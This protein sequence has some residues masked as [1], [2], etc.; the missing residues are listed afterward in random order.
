MKAAWRVA[1]IVGGLVGAVVTGTVVGL[2][3][4]GLRRDGRSP[5]E[6]GERPEPVVTDPYRWPRP[7]REFTVAADDGLPLSVEETDPADGG[8]PDLTVVLVHGYTVDRRCWYFQRR[9]LA[10]LGRRPGEPRVRVVAY[11]QRSHGRSGRGPR[12]SCTLDQL[13]RDLDAVLRVVAPTGPVVLVGHSMG[14]MTIMALAEQHPELFLER[15]VGVALIGTSAGELGR[16]GLPRPVLSRYNPVTLG[17]GRLAGWQ[18]DLVER[19]RRVGNNLTWG[20]VRAL[21]F[22]SRQVDPH[23]VELV[24]RMIAETPVTVITHF[25]ETLGTHNRYAALAALRQC[26]VLVLSGDADRLTPFSHSTVIAEAL[27]DAELVRV[28]G[29]GHMVMLERPELVDRELV[30]LLRRCHDSGAAGEWVGK[31][32]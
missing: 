19:T 16:Q 21:A 20:L 22:G 25:L 4:R 17:L 30:D 2:A 12:E 8:D 23:L 13:G 1:G 18:P 6:T 32:A 15:V 29:A 27:P 9:T 31:E 14:G 24:H 10:E 7:D 11:D 5:E 28:P 3:A 26:Q